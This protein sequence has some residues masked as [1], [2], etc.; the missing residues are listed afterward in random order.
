VWTARAATGKA[1]PGASP[2]AYSESGKVSGLYAIAA[3][4]A[5]TREGLEGIGLAALRTMR[6][7][8]ATA[9]ATL[10]AEVAAR[11]RPMPLTAAIDAAAV[12]VAMLKAT[13]EWAAA[14]P[15]LK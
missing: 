1:A 15:D 8:D 4:D 9:A 11:V 13:A 7:E 3:G 6:N 14:N 2:S 5:A 12:A 10:V